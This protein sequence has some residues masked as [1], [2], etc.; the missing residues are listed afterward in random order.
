MISLISLYF[1]IKI[2]INEY[3][4]DSS[5]YFTINLLFSNFCNEFYL[6]KYLTLR[7]NLKDKDDFNINQLIFKL[8]L[9]I[10]CY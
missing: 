3:I 4:F 6:F 5:D 1:R 8:H 7:N 2:K 10:Y 9:M